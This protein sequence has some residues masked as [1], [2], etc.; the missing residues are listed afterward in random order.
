MSHNEA[1]NRILST[2]GSDSG[3]SSGNRVFILGGAR[4]TAKCIGPYKDYY[5]YEIKSIEI[6]IEIGE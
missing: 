4:I 1:L 6:A 5:K 3:D 2:V